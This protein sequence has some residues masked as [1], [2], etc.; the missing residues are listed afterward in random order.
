MRRTIPLAA[1]I[2]P[3]LALAACDA[4]GDPPEGAR[5]AGPYA[6]ATAEKA[7]SLEGDGLEIGDEAF[8][9][10]AGRS[11]IETTLGKTLG[12]PVRRATNTEC[13]AGTVDFTDYEGGLTLHFTDG[14]LVGWNWHLPYEGDAPL[15]DEVGVAGGVALGMGGEEVRALGGFERLEDSTLGEEFRLGS[16]GGFIEAGEVATLF[17]GTQCFIRGDEAAG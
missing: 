10:N 15:N 13:E 1:V 12:E 16:I 3:A 14:Q 8:L 7:V 17:A 4:G 9:F 2:A 5:E 6:S 11:E